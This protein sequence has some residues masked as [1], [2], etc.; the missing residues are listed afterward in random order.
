[1]KHLKPY[2]L[3]E[4]VSS[5]TKLF[6]EIDKKS[7]RNLIIKYGDKAISRCESIIADIY[8]ILLELKDQGIK[9]EVGYTTST[10][11]MRE[12]YPI[13]Y[14]RI[15]SDPDICWGPFSNLNNPEKMDQSETIQRIK[16]Y[17][18]ITEDEELERIYHK[19]DLF[20]PP[21]NKDKKIYKMIIYYVP[22]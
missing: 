4:R 1:M 12:N 10:L 2:T 15:V 9:C 20:N 5:E 21:E 13:L 22:N 6:E 18:E 14:V 3:Y 17:L 19:D 8:D 16:E 11:S 7:L